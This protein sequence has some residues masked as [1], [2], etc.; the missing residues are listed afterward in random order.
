MCC[1]NAIENPFSALNK[2]SFGDPA[3]PSSGRM[4]YAHRR[5]RRAGKRVTREQGPA[6]DGGGTAAR[7]TRQRKQV[8]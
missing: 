4:S 8:L 7:S 3:G 2:P 6:A 1:S 5:K